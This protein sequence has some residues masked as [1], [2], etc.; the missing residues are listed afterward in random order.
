MDAARRSEG[1]GGRVPLGAAEA[2]C[3]WLSRSFFSSDPS[4]EDMRREA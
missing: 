3:A 1:G 2:G 4:F